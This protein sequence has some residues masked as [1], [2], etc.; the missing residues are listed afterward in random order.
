MCMCVRFV[1]NSKSLGFDSL[2]GKKK[3]AE[4]G[5][6]MHWTKVVEYGAARQVET[7]EKIHGCNKG[8]MERVG[9]TE[10]NAR[11]RVRWRQTICCGDP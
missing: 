8:D 4:E 1:V 10:E 2:S 5:Y 11:D 6:W 9:V 7:I 3:C